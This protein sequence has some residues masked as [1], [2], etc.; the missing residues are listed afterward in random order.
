MPQLARYLEPTKPS[1]VEKGFTAIHIQSGRRISMN[2]S[3]RFPMASAYKFPIAVHLLMLV[4][5]GKVQLNHFIGIEPKDV[6]PG[7]VPLTDD[8]EFG[9]SFVSVQ[10]LLEMML[11]ISDNTASDL[12][13]RLAGGP[14]A[15]TSRMR[16]LGIEDISIDRSTIEHL[17][18]MFRLPLPP[19]SDW[20]PGRHV[21]LLISAPADK[22]RA[23]T[24]Q[25]A[26]SAGYRNA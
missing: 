20:G 26:R 22:Q 4:D 3:E 25:Y 1:S 12:I 8:F 10:D 23:A 19:E 21:N 16:A 6:R 13:L 17:F 11:T 5:E 9:E 15:V 7:G 18:D 24:K 2:G 14:Q